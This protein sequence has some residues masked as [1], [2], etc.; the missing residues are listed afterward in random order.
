MSLN[1]PSWSK[2]QPDPKFQNQLAK[3]GYRKIVG[4]D[5]V[6]RGAMAGPLV[7]AAVCLSR[8]IIGIDDSKRLSLERRRKLCWQILGG[9][10]NVSIGLVSNLEIDQLGLAKAQYLA[11]KR[12]IKKIKFDLLLTD[13]YLA[14]TSTK[15]IQAIRGDQL[16]YPVAA[17]S[18]VA[19]CYRDQLMK[20]YHNFW[21]E[22]DWK[23]NVGYGTKNH[24]QAIGKFGPTKLHRLTF[25]N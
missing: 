1:R 24:Q 23:N 11:Y 6:G 25:G 20:T 2:N 13:N 19:K 8:P 10:I 15:Q 4:V 5:E 17:A 16:F 21:P 14:P 12:A 9:S 18:I 3:L 7:V 22:Y